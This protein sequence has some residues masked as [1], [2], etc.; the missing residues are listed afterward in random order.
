MS[1]HF[2]GLTLP[3]DFSKK[4]DEW[5]LR[6]DPTKIKKHPPHV[7][8]VTPFN[9]EEINKVREELTQ[10]VTTYQLIP[11]PLLRIGQFQGAPE[12]HVAVQTTPDLLSLHTKINKVVGLKP[13][14]QF[15]PHITLGKLSSAESEQAR[16]ELTGKTVFADNLVIFIW[17]GQSWDT[18][19]QHHFTKT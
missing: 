2:I 9:S 1:R 17:N 5:R 14:W 12:S 6:A 15:N 13:R 16:H 4:V 8:L 19:W 10:F 3:H 18:E 7:T 11:L